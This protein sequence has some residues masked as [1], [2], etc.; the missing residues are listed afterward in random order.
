L[1]DSDDAKIVIGDDYNYLYMKKSGF[2][3]R[4][5][6]SVNDDPMFAPL[7]PEILDLE[8]S[9]NGCSKGCPFCSPAGTLVNTPTGMTA[10][11]EI[12]EGDNVMG[13][14]VDLNEM[15]RQKVIECY[16][17]E[18][19]GDMFDIEL[20]DGRILSM[21]PEHP[22]WTLNRGYVQAKDLT[23]NDDILLPFLPYITTITTVKCQYITTVS[24]V[25]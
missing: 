8:I 13:F 12:V 25:F 18:Y 4:W 22:V 20:D 11:E 5:G 9:V 17:R 10:I 19:D 16:N 24:T 21:T 3:Q 7:G 15:N 23:L 2:F 14:D 6:K 1:V